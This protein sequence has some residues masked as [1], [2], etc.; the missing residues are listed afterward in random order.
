MGK[1][2]DDVVQKE[3]KSVMKMVKDT[4]ADE[5]YGRMP[6]TG[7]QVVELKN[8]LR[9]R[10]QQRYKVMLMGCTPYLGAPESARD[11]FYHIRLEKLKG[12]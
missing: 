12:G 5:I 1:E 4:D 6:L 2:I 3:Y 9:A 10:L 8:M 7:E 11:E